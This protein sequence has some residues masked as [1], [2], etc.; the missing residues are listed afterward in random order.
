MQTQL[1][2]NIDNQT[3]E[4]ANYYAKEKGLSVNEMIE[5]Y[6]KWIVWNETLIRT[7]NIINKISSFEK[8]VEQNEKWNKLENFLSKNRFNLPQNYQFNREELYDR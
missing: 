2:L 1:V 8:P 7:P 4:L 3:V 6:L 5:F